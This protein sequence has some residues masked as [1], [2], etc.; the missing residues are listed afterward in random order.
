MGDTKDPII[1][2]FIENIS[3]FT[4]RHLRI[5]AN[6]RIKIRPMSHPLFILD[7]GLNASLQQQLRQ[8][9][10]K[11]ILDHHIPLDSSLP[12]SRKLAKQLNVARNTVVL[13]YE[14][15]LDDG[16]LIARERS[17]YFVNPNILDHSVQLDSVSDERHTSGTKPDWQGR[18]KLNPT[19]QENITKPND[20]QNF[21][22]PFIYGQFDPDLF[23]T[24]HWRECCRDNVSVPAIRSWAA[25]HFVADDP[26]LIEQIHTRVLPRRGV[27]ANP[28]EILITI[29]CQ[30]GLYMLAQLL[31]DKNTT[32]GLEDPGFVD[33][34]NIASLNP[35]KL[36]ALPVDEGG[37]IVDEGLAECDC[38]FV[39]PSHQYPTTV[40]MPLDRR[41]KLLEM[42]SQEDFLIIEDDYECEANFHHAPSPALKSLDKHGRVIYI[43]SFS[44]TLAPGLRIGYLVANKE[45]IA[46]ARS[47]RRLMLRHPPANN[48]RSIGLFI[49]RGYYDSL[50]ATLVK[51]YQER[52]KIMADA[53]QKH[54]PGL[55]EQP[56]FGGSCYWVKGPPGLDA[57]ELR[58]KAAEHGI[59]IESGDIHF[60]GAHSP[61]N[62][63]RLGYS[64]INPKLIEP[65]IEK[66]SHIMRELVS[67]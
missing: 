20:W 67:A 5:G 35:S 43:G 28:E 15:L 19:K 65:G 59:L 51:A 14:H 66:L 42:A 6:N 58:D 45:L 33:M 30:Q 18:F 26:M 39:T 2:F 9:I 48:Q 49:A 7:A 40:T 44:K 47:L 36:K 4:P 21:Q 17:G 60:L 50:S 54:M 38:V 23:P 41:R 12:S 25:D 29:G 11:A 62:Y 3:Y 52:H 56:T 13:A 24:N 61:K 64:S 53:L 57:R 31:L 10:A 46:E 27:W 16:Y 8:Q 37:L 32:M 55:A 63:F 22:Y 1:Q 34:R